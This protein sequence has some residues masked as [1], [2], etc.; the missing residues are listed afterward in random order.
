DHLNS[1]TLMSVPFFVVA[2]TFLERGNV[3]R[4]LI[5]A[6]S[7]WLGRIH[8]STALVCVLTT[9]IFAA[10]SGS[11]LAT[12]MAMGTILIPSMLAQKYDRPFA[13]GVV[14]ASGTLGILIP[15]SLAL[16]VYGIVAELSVPKLF[17]AGVIPGIL[18]ATLLGLWV[19]LYAR[20]KAYLATATENRSDFLQANLKAIP[21]LS[22]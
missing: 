7:A 11:S 9:T 1:N 19:Y 16:I 8:G 14:G 15:P 21:A 4:V 6:A 20:R 5:G 13:L 18:Q 22:L 17:L 12:A 10:I 2:A 3:A